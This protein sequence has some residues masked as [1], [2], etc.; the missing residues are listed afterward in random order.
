MTELHGGSGSGRTG[1]RFRI[2]MVA[3]CPFPCPRG[4]PVRIARMAEALSERSHDVHVI[5]YHL[6]EGEAIPGVTVHRMPAVP[7]YS[8]M[9]PGPS[10]Q[11]LLVMDP[12]LAVTLR[13]VLRR[14]QFDL[15][16]AHHFEGLGVALLAAPDRTKIVFDAHTL[17]RSE[18]PYYR[19]GLPRNVLR[20]IGGV[21]DGKL[22]ARADHVV[23]VTSAIKSQLHNE[24]GFPE[25]FVTVV[26]NGIV[27]ERFRPVGTV[28]RGDSPVL[29]FSGNLAPY[30]GIEAMLHAFR[31]VRRS[32]PDARLLFAVENAAAFKRYRR[33]VEKLGLDNHVSVR[34]TAFAELPEVLASAWIALNPRIECDGMPM[35]VLNYMAAAL[36]IVCFPGCA[37]GLEHGTTAWIAADASVAAFAEGIEHLLANPS[38]GT[39]LGA[40]ARSRLDS[41]RS[42]D[43]VASKLERVYEGVLAGS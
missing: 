6:A 26:E 22:P 2:A 27:A 1:H 14:G 28:A 13:R 16:H 33:L 40:Q 9:E 21:L 23:A 30:Q 4:T 17:L 29:V 38:V 42:W 18:L 24:F 36:P 19:L 8:R 43:H 7:T 41:G 5:T 37:E 3:A 12:L 39:R 25:G 11:K 32:Y 10:Y 15:V 35:K 20:W 31:R 34:A